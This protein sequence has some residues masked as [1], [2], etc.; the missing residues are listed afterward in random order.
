MVSKGSGLPVARA[1]IARTAANSQI[2][3]SRIIVQERSKENLLERADGGED[4]GWVSARAVL[5]MHAR[6]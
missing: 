2:D 1:S 5:E 3:A 6:R 4:G